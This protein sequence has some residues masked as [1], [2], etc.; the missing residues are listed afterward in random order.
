MRDLL[1]PS[2][3]STVCLPDDDELLG[4]LTAPSAIE[5]MSGGKIKVESK[6]DIRKRIGRSTDK[7]DAVVEAFYTVYG[8]WTSAYG[9]RVCGT[10]KRG[11]LAAVNGVAR[12]SCPHCRAPVTDEEED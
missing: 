8:S 5:V 9:T 3:D 1:D 2:A 10:C 12:T 7:A 6:D 11:F 4:D